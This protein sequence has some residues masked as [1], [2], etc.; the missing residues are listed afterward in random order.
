MVVVPD[1]RLSGPSPARKRLMERYN[2]RAVIHLPTQVFG[3]SATTKNHRSILVID[4]RQPD[5][6]VLFVNLRSMAADLAH[7]LIK[8]TP[9]AIASILKG[10]EE[11]TFKEDN[12]S[13]EYMIS[14][15]KGR[16][17]S[18]IVPSHAEWEMG[19]IR[20][21]LRGHADI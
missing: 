10:G 7:D 14:T 2:V 6:S 13:S 16:D 12:V 11:G 3:T 4:N 8:N 21:D 20:A 18:L 9:N 5:T 19:E 17:Y 1:S 15:L